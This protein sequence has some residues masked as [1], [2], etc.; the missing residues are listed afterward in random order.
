MRFN[1]QDSIMEVAC[2]I[3]NGNLE[4]VS[5]EFHLI[6]HQPQSRLDRMDEWCT[7][8]HGNSGLTEKCLKS[9]ITTLE[10]HQQLLEFIQRYIPDP[11]T[12]V[13]AGNS[14]HVDRLFLLKEFPLVVEHLHYRIV[15]VSTLKEL[16]RRWFPEMLESAP[17]KALCHRYG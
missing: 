7:K 2:L 11:R 15:D 17:K 8:T 13:L 4:I 1:H 9:P 5:D 16:S 10:A 12:G 14:V 6:I 3:T